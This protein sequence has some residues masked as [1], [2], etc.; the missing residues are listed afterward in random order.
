MKSMKVFPFESFN[1]P[2]MIDYKFVPIGP[3]L[4]QRRGV[5]NSNLAV[6]VNNIIHKYTCSDTTQIPS[7]VIKSACSHFIDQLCII[8]ERTL[9]KGEI[10]ADNTFSAKTLI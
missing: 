4:L 10:F 1:L 5:E 6:P 7:L 9:M 3:M 8:C 2:Y